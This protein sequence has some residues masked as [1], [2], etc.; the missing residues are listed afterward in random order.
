MSR[1]S[2]GPHAPGS[3]KDRID[4]CWTVQYLISLHCLVTVQ[5]E[6]GVTSH[7]PGKAVNGDVQLTEECEHTYTRIYIHGSYHNI[8]HI[9]YSSESI[10]PRTLIATQLRQ[11]CAWE[12]KANVLLMLRLAENYKEYWSTCVAHLTSRSVLVT[13]CQLWSRVTVAHAVEC[14]QTTLVWEWCIGN[15]ANLAWLD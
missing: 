4:Q 3:G 1:A 8:L 13:V 14:T 2:W 7:F 12:R 6:C 10:V 5:A 11:S 15:F 9:Q